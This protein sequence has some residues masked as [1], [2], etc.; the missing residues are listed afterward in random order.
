MMGMLWMRFG[1]ISI[2]VLEYSGTTAAVTLGIL[3]WVFE[4]HRRLPWS[5]PRPAEAFDFIRHR[6]YRQNYLI[7]TSC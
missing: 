5:G 1:R 7:R 6:G 2:T 3:C 4:N